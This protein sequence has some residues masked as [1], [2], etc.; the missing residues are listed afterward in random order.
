MQYRCTCSVGIGGETE[1]TRESGGLPRGRGT[2]TELRSKTGEQ[3]E[4]KMVVTYFLCFVLGD[5]SMAHVWRSEGIFH[6]VSPRT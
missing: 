6:Y 5:I 4:S 2:P 1:E 3:A